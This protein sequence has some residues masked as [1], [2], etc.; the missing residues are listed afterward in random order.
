MLFDTASISADDAELV[1]P[2]T[3]LLILRRLECFPAIVHMLCKG[4]RTTMLMLAGTNAR[5]LLPMRNIAGKTDLWILAEPR[6]CALT[7]ERWYRLGQPEKR[8]E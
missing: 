8:Q 7:L 6:G 3:G 1:A 5:I 2:Q 4:I